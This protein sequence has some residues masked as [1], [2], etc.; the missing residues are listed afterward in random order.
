MPIECLMTVTV[1]FLH[2]ATIFVL[3]YLSSLKYSLFH[4]HLFCKCPKCLSDIQKIFCLATTF[5]PSHL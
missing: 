4:T 2:L 5:F 3:S 1:F